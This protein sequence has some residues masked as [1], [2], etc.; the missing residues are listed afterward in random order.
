MSENL[1][2]ITHG[3]SYRNTAPVADH[4]R[5]V[6]SVGALSRTS[7]VIAAAAGILLCLDTIAAVLTNA[8]GSKHAPSGLGAVDIVFG[9]I[10]AFSVAAA[11]LLL[12]WL[13]VRDRRIA[14]GARRLSDGAFAQIHESIE[15]L[16]SGAFPSRKA[17]Q[18]IEDA[19]SIIGP[20]DG[21]EAVKAITTLQLQIVRAATALDEAC[22]NVSET[23]QTLL[24]NIERYE[25]SIRG[26]RDGLWDWDLVNDA[27]YLSA[28]WKAILGYEEHELENNR[29]T[30]LDMLHP[31]DRKATETALIAYLD[32][33]TQNFEIDYQMLHKDGTYRWIL[34][35]AVALRDELGLPYRISGAHTD[36]T[37]RR[38]AQQEIVSAK[39]AAEAA[40]QAKS[41]FLANMSHEL[42]TPMNAIIGFSELLNKQAFG[43]LNERQARYVANILNSG[44]HLLQLINSILDLAKVEAGRMTLDIAAF[45]AVDAVRD[46]I[47]VIRPLAA[48][49]SINLL[50]SD[51]PDTIEISGDRAKMQQVIYNLVS[52]AIKFSPDGSTVTIRARLDDNAESAGGRRLVLSVADRGIGLKPEDRDRIFNEFEQLDSS[53]S[54]SQQGTGLGLTLTRRFVN[55]HGGSIW[56]ESAGENHGSTF[57]VAIPVTANPGADVKHQSAENTRRLR[58][59]DT[60]RDSTGKRSAT[61]DRRHRV[62]LVEDNAANRELISEVLDGEGFDVEMAESAEA[63]IALAHRL[64]PDLILMDMALPGMDGLEATRLLT[65]NGRTQHIPIVGLSAHAMVGDEDK[66]ISAGCCAYITKPID[67]GLFP[68]AIRTIISRNAA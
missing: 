2:F 6:S 7:C 58:L 29:R 38:Q 31:D 17:T 51:L 13:E 23:Q 14:E 28:Q 37:E 46:A 27:F 12:R 47:E 57:F 33:S 24:R 61:G 44:R 67:T 19:A 48:K 1:P 68:T 50:A 25:L 5:I 45:D 26:S 11:V 49:K 63:G 55:M 34:A 18:S 65:G 22:A 32:G 9:C 53:F 21:S 59:V 3:T 35:R 56:V 40:S 41:Q 39:E 8:G 16:S 54:R 15:A 52:N 20:G 4:S 62:L 42:R 10:A 66:A 64:L 36:I 60:R 30:W 43:A